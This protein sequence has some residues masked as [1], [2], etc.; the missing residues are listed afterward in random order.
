ML[1]P[2][3]VCMKLLKDEK[4]NKTKFVLILIILVNK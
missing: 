3:I 1:L 2:D 4:K